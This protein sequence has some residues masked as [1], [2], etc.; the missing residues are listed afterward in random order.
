M[1]S[2][3]SQKKY[4][5]II[6]GKKKKLIQRKIFVEIM[7]RVIFRIKLSRMKCWI[8]IKLLS[9]FYYLNITASIRSK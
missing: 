4:R 2:I 6:F 3:S 7:I 1:K 5:V 9:N 8:S